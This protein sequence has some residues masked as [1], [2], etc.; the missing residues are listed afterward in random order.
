M[1]NFVIVIISRKIKWARNAARIMNKKLKNAFNFSRQYSH[2][3]GA[4][5]TGT[6]K[7]A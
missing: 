6:L 2:N 7:F 4:D 5:S 3:L 1:S